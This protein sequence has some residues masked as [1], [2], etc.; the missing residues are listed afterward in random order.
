MKEKD[1]LENWSARIKSS[2][3]VLKAEEDLLKFIR[4]YGSDHYTK[5]LALETELAATKELLLNTKTCL[6]ARVA[7]HERLLSRVYKAI[8]TNSIEPLK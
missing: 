5:I 1:L 6:A 8:E 4:D 7:D 2:Y 3:E